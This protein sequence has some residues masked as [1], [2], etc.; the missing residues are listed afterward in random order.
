MIS[1]ILGSIGVVFLFI[2]IAI[3]R[4]TITASKMPP[5]QTMNRKMAEMTDARYGGKRNWLPYYSEW[6]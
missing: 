5:K 1:F 4:F 2:G 6:F 3:L